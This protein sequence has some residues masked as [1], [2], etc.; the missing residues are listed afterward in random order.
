MQT[1]AIHRRRA[2]TLVELLVV[3]AII[4]VLIALLLP[5]V[6]Q[7]RE[8]AR[9]SSCRNNMK[10]VG[11]ALHNYHDVFG[12]FPSGFNGLEM[13]WTA[14]IL[15]QLEQ[16]NIYDTLIFT[17]SGAGNW[18]HDGSPNERACGTVVNVYRC[19]SMAVPE[20]IDNSGIPGRVP[21]SYRGV[22]SS[23]AV[24]DDLST[25]P[26][27][28]LPQVA[29]EMQDLNGTLYGGS[30]IRFADITDGTTNTVVV[31]ESWTNPSYVKDGQGMDYWQFGCPQSG[32]WDPIPGDKGGTEYSEGVGS[33]WP[34]IN[35]HL[36]PTQPG[37]IMELAF[38]S[39]H[40][41]GAQ[42]TLGD[43]SVRFIAETVDIVTY[44]GLG[45]RN[46]HEIAGQF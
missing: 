33:T 13:L 32:G 36:D 18:N 24:S 3:I 34:K 25:I 40:P 31:G 14:S 15:P 19:P 9:R 46:G 11:L 28:S 37:V 5:A 20:H 10:Q 6:Q 29:L 35:A 38:G 16:N 2:F 22:A 45:S 8:A 7:A 41:G 4:G 44:R 43:G 12:E 27:S 17:E 30:H 26:S 42:F 39:Y 21:I 23:Q 1:V